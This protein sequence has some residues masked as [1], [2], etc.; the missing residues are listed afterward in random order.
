[1]SKASFWNSSSRAVR[2]FSVSKDVFFSLGDHENSLVLLNGGE[3]SWSL[4]SDSI[5]GW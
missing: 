3:G 4:S 5:V 1:M 2:A